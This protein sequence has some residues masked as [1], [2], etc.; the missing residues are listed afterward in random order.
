MIVFSGLGGQVGLGGLGP[1]PIGPEVGPDVL[2]FGPIG[3]WL[4]VVPEGP[5]LEVVPEGVGARLDI[6]EL[7]LVGFEVSFVDVGLVLGPEVDELIFVIVELALNVLPVIFAVE[8]VG[9]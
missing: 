2:E 4:D 5:W 3:L 1:G 7:I 9:I 8:F 6:V